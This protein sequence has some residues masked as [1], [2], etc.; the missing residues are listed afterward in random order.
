MATV[1]GWDLSSS[2][3]PDLLCEVTLALLWQVEH[4][5]RGELSRLTPFVTLVKSLHVNVSV[6]LS[7]KCRLTIVT[8]LPLGEWKGGIVQCYEDGMH[9]IIAKYYHNMLSC[10]SCFS[11]RVEMAAFLLTIFITCKDFFF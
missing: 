8:F 1:L 4:G 2:S 7:V 6:S 10:S 11:S 3:A 9:C 5:Y